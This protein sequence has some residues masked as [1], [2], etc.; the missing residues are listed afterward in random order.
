MAL[1]LI[2][3]YTPYLANAVNTRFVTKQ[4]GS[5]HLLP[6]AGDLPNNG[7]LPDV[8]YIDVSN[9]RLSM[10]QRGLTHDSDGNCLIADDESITFR[11]RVSY[12]EISQDILFLWNEITMDIWEATT[13]N[14]VA[15]FELGKP[16]LIF[17]L[18]AP[19]M[20]F[21]AEVFCD[22]PSPTALA[23][24]DPAHEWLMWENGVVQYF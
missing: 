12:Y 10:F 14:A 20:L 8:R 22:P 15:G 18:G 24:S 16:G 3:S 21:S 9:I 11:L 2:Y 7:W 4:G 13:Y 19:R 1:P 17:D 23:L 6:P 5:W